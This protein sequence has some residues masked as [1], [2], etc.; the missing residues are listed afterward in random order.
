MAAVTDTLLLLSDCTMGHLLYIQNHVRVRLLFILFTVIEENLLTAYNHILLKTGKEE[1]NQI[2]MH[3]IFFTRNSVF[4]I[5]SYAMKIN[6][7]Q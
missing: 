6:K 7:R 5:K 2:T 1:T 3:C 4:V